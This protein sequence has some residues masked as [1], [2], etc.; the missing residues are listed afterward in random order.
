MMDKRLKGGDKE[1][2]QGKSRQIDRSEHES[3]WG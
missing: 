3:Q 2:T 1:E